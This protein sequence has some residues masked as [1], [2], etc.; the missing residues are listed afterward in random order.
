MKTVL[1]LVVLSFVFYI[2]SVGQEILPCP[3][4]FVSGP[5]D[6]VL[7]GHPGVF[8][9]RVEGINLDK[10]G[11]KWTVATFDSIS[12]KLI[13]SPGLIIDGQG[14]S[15]IKVAPIRDGDTATVEITGLP[16][17]CRLTA[18]ANF[19]DESTPPPNKIFPLK[20][21]EFSTGPPR[22][23]KE[24]LDA[25]FTQ[26]NNEPSAGAFILEVFQK[27]TS[28]SQVER[29]IDNIVKSIAFRKFDVTRITF[30]VAIG[31]KNLTEYW[32]IPPGAEMPGLDSSI[33]DDKVVEINLQNYKKDVA[34]I[35]A[36]KQ[37]VSLKAKKK[38]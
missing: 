4:I 15:R 37:K 23:H 3:T 18:S 31:D 1:M 32:M 36:V 13:I 7:P 35:F 6:L 14:T 25:F 26:L 27:N 16:E 5:N 19:M 29:K 21:D 2:Q 20:K 24:R 33:S 10:I 30:Y 28:Q 17:N 38:R 8:T 12:G 11:Y 34:K 9:A 22:I